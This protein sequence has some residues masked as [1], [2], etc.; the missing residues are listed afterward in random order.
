MEGSRLG[1]LPWRNYPQKKEI[2]EFRVICT[3]HLCSSPPLRSHLEIGIFV[4]LSKF[5]PKLASFSR[6]VLIDHQWSS[7]KRKIWISRVILPQTLFGRVRK[8]VRY[9][10]PQDMIGN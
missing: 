9:W 7:R 3:C 2:Y 4:Y 1:P 10:V 5:C 6:I 8:K